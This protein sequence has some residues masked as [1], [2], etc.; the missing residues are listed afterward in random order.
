MY[1]TIILYIELILYLFV[2]FL[3]I[4]KF[5]EFFEKCSSI[6]L[7]LTLY[8]TLLLTNIRYLTYTGAPT[9]DISSPYGGC[10]LASTTITLVPCFICFYIISNV[11]NI[12]IYI[13]K[14]LISIDYILLY[15]IYMVIYI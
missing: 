10:S 7:Y 5:E 15:R 8:L 2:N 1:I 11:H 6:I 4:Q 12:D 14:S 13:Y 9:Q 3:L